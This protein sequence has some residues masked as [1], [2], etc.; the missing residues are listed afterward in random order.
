[1]N[2][3]NLL[4][5]NIFVYIDNDKEANIAKNKVL[6]D[7]LINEQYLLQTTILNKE[8]SEFE[9]LVSRNLYNDIFTEPSL[10]NWCETFNCNKYKWSENLKKYYE[11]SGI[12]LTKKRLIQIKEEISKKI[13]DAEENILIKENSSSFDAL[14]RCLENTI[15]EKY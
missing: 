9:D 11:H 7:S 14:I 15:K 5:K 6:E 12:T 10:Q 13:E 1:M 4:C 2:Y 3:Q 8:E